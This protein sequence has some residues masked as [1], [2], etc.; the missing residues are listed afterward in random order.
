VVLEYRVVAHLSRVDSVEVSVK[1]RVD[2]KSFLFIEIDIGVVP[3]RH[4][5]KS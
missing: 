5:N 3:S 4:G 1:G 2:M